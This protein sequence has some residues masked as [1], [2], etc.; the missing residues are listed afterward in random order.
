MRV[1]N[2]RMKLVHK[3]GSKIIAVASICIEDSLVVHDLKL[4][5]NDNGIFLLM[6]SRKTPYG[7]FKDIVHPLN[8]E[9]REMIQSILIA[10]YNELVEKEADTDGHSDDV[11]D[12]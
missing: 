11:V 5:K 2:V 3:A 4:I 6:P 10:H 12:K 1:D 7:E 8:T 9:T